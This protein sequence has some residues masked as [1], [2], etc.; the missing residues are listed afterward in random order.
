MA[1]NEG[2]YTTKWLPNHKNALNWPNQR[3]VKI[4]P[5]ITHSAMLGDPIVVTL[6]TNPFIFV[7]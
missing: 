4:T 7:Q 1:Q 3:P 6:V 5:K 2:Y